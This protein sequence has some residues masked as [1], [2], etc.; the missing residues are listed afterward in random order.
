M[1][2]D[3]LLATFAGY[4]A[5]F[6]LSDRPQDPKVRDY[7]IE[8]VRIRTASGTAVLDAEL[9]LPKGRGAFPRWYS[10]PV[11]VHR[12]RMKKLRATNHFSCFRIT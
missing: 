7:S 11:Q 5:V 10:S 2:I 4:L 8:T 6:G 1:N 9:T 12:T 3:L